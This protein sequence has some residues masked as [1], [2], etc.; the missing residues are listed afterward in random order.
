MK[1]KII[2]IIFLVYIFLFSILGIVI[3]DN[4]VSFEERRKLQEFPKFTLNN[5]YVTKVDKY[6]LDHFPFRSNFRSI[7]V[8]YNYNV[9]NMLDNNGI[10]LKDNYI[11]KSDYK[12]NK[13]SLNNFINKTNKIQ[14]LLTNEN[15]TY[16]MIVPDKN[17]Y[18][19]DKNFLR[20]DY[21]TLYNSLNTLNMTNIDI[22]NTLSLEDYYE[23]DTHFKQE[24]LDK[25][26]LEMS[27]VM[28]FNYK[29]VYYNKTCYDK[30]YGVY[31]S[32]SALKRKPETLC[33]LTSSVVDNAYVR[34]LENN[35][36]HKV[37]NVNKLN[38]FD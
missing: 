2:T 8:N 33:Y 15:K 25:V 20:L 21:D 22:R 37:Y 24:K 31:Y 36:L 6:F 35:N 9:L 17:Y 3:K 27:K 34:Y 10:Y 14:N 11:F 23:T 13:N 30:F 18:L 7:K 29:N 19:E 12:I 4:E 26:V 38:S 32:E 28:D 5:T 16:L 1:D